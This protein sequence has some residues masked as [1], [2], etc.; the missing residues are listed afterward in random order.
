M[1]KAQEPPK[2][3]MSF[4]LPHQEYK[5]ILAAA[6]AA[7]KTPAEAVGFGPDALNSIEQM[8]HGY[9]TARLFDRAAVIYG[10]I[11]RLSPKRASAWRGL[12]A[13][14][15]STKQYFEATQCYQFALRYDPKDV[16]AKVFW[17]EVLCLVDQKE[18]GLQLLNEVIAAGTENVEYKPYITR[19]RGVVSAGGGIPPRLV[20][21]RDGQPVLTDTATMLTDAG[22]QLDPDREIT[23][24][25]ML[26]NPQLKATIAEM[27]KAVQEGRLTMAQVGGFTDK[28]LNGAY[29]VACKY[30]EAGQVGEAME[31]AGYLIFLQPSDERFYQLTG[32][33]FQRLKL[34]NEATHFYGL[35]LAMNNEDA[36]TQV[37]LGESHIMAGEIDRG[38]KDVQR[39]LDLAEKRTEFADVADRARVLL[40]QFG[41]E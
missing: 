7:G 12:G 6:K 5:D 2:T 30:A 20:L 39:G 18:R 32:I 14:A 36:R 27:V 29:A 34:Y 23:P 3:D 17:G 24:A 40:R 4:D 38:L 28:E 26:K 33:C 21:M 8:A 35:A 1:A 15:H 11:L 31:I 10:F 16:I 37:Y 22:V 9:F 13:C 19:A 41:H 25:D